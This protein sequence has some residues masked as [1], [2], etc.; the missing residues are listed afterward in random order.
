MKKIKTTS[1]NI[2]IQQVMKLHASKNICCW[3]RLHWMGGEGG[4]WLRGALQPSFLVLKTK[5]SGMQSKWIPSWH[6]GG[7]G[8]ATMKQE[9]QGHAQFMCSWSDNHKT[10]S[11]SFQRKWWKLKTWKKVGI[12]S[13]SVGELKHVTWQM[14]SHAPTN[15]ATKSFDNSMPKFKYG[16]AARN[17]AAVRYPSCHAFIIIII[18]FIFHI[19]YGTGNIM[20]EVHAWLSQ[21]CIYNLDIHTQ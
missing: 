14:A 16:W 12:K 21:L 10:L 3:Q 20:H 15:W 4:E 6:V 19:S 11:K 5:L 2:S 9:A 18:E 7:N 1:Y 17:Q 8:A 13:V